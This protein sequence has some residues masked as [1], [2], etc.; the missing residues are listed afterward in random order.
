MD[1]YREQRNE[2]E[3]FLETY[4]RI[5]IEPFKDRVYAEKVEQP[6]LC[7]AS[8]MADFIKVNNV[9]RNQTIEDNVWTH[10]TGDVSEL[11]LAICLMVISVCL[12]LTGKLIRQN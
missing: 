12:W 6:C 3:R 11:Q 5:G 1:V 8:I 9:I 10:V 4:R 2:S 7:G